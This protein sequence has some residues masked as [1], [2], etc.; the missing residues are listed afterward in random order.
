M[1]FQK[2]PAKKKGITNVIKIQNMVTKM[3]D[4]IWSLK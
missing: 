3:E 4:E 1:P 2:Q